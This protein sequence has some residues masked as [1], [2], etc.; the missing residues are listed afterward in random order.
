MLLSGKSILITGAARGIGYAISRAAHVH[1]ANVVMADIDAVMLAEAAKS[2]PGARHLA[3]DVSED[4]SIRAALEG[5]SV[6]DGLVNN[7]A[8]LDESNSA[9]VQGARFTRVMDVN[10]LSTVKV[11]QA[12]LP[13]LRASA[14]AAVVNT[15]STQSFF[16]QANAL[17]YA[18]AKGAALN[19]TRCMAVDFAPL[20]IRVN[21]VAPGFIDTRMA[22]MASG[23]HEHETDWFKDIYVSA[24]KIPMARAGT[25]EDCAGAYIFLLSSLSCYITGQ[26]I[27]VDGG[28]TATY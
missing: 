5:L 17:S 28:L 9:T 6:L 7:A 14:D 21:G 23:A 13:L 3:M 20:S 8:I 12:C 15:L 1:G 22:I 18:A 24:R 25:P 2:I 11:T 4:S 10:A 26:V 27:K 19:I 16:G